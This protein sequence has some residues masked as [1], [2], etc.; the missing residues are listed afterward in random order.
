MFDEVRCWGNYITPIEGIGGRPEFQYS[1]CP[2][3]QK[4]LRHL[5]ASTAA[6]FVNW[7]VAPV[8]E[9]GQCC[10][11]FIPKPDDAEET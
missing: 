7:I 11:Y 2:L 5:S 9:A 4:C 3:K 1:P 8:P 10:Q 6:C